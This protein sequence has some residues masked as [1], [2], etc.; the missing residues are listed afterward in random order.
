MR[1]RPANALAKLAVRP[2]GINA[3]RPWLP[4]GAA[5]RPGLVIGAPSMAPRTRRSAAL[6]SAAVPGPNILDRGPPPISVPLLG[7]SAKEGGVHAA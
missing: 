4:S 5:T 3:R 1:P 7:R 6:R 2:G